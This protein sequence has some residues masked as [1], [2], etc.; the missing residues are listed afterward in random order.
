VK[1]RITKK[2]PKS[3]I[4]KRSAKYAI[5]KDALIEY[6]DLAMVKRF[7]TDRGKLVSRRISGVTGKQQRDLTVAVKRA[8]YLG[9][10]PSGGV[11]RKFN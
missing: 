3:R 6:K 2:R 11:N 10:L 5:P 1:K 4:R 7:L 9:L 8:R